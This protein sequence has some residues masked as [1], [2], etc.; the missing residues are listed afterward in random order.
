MAGLGAQGGKVKVELAEKTWT[1]IGKPVSG[2]R[3][4]KLKLKLGKRLTCFFSVKGHPIR[5]S[6]EIFEENKGQVHASSTECG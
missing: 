3:E 5:D 1:K 4:E 2:P 6:T